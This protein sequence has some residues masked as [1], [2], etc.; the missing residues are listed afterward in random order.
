MN[1][2]VFGDSIAWGSHDKSGGGWVNRLQSFFLWQSDGHR[3]Y[4]LG[5]YNDDSES[6]SRRLHSEA[7]C[8]DAGL[9]VL[10]IGVNDA[11]GI[12]SASA[13]RTPLSIF[14]RNIDG[15]TSQARKTASRIVWAGLTRV[16]ERLTMP[17]PY[18]PDQ[19]YENSSIAEFDCAIRQLCTKEKLP[20][21]E[22]ASVLTTE[23][24]ADGIH[25][26]DNGHTKI[27]KRVLPAVQLALAAETPTPPDRNQ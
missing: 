11:S 27:L 22:L 19:Y 15:L 8:R 4:N 10:A 18:A 2:C 24:L 17:I 14:C 6:L 13:R 9:I 23:D 7:A 21:I 3:V 26:N 5:V 12:G 1:I 20:Y 16:D 25:P